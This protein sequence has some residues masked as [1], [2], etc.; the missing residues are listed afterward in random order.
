[1]CSSGEVRS[2]PFVMGSAQSLYAC[3]RRDEAK[4]L[5]A[6]WTAIMTSCSLV[7]PQF[8]LQFPLKAFFSLLSGLFLCIGGYRVVAGKGRLREVL[9][10]ISRMSMVFCFPLTAVVLISIIF[11]AS[12]AIVVF[13]TA[14]VYL[15]TTVMALLGFFCP[16]V[17]PVRKLA[18]FGVDEGHSGFRTGPMAEFSGFLKRSLRR[19]VNPLLEIF[20]FSNPFRMF[21]FPAEV[22]SPELI[23]G[24]SDSLVENRGISG[25]RVFIDLP[26]G[27]RMRLCCHKKEDCKGP[28]ILVFGGNFITIPMM[29]LLFEQEFS[30]LKGKG[31]IIITVN[32]R[33]FGDSTGYNTAFTMDQDTQSIGE[34][35]KQEYPDSPIIVYGWS[36]GGAFAASFAQT[37]PECTSALI[38]D[39]SFISLQEVVQK[40]IVP[41][42]VPSWIVSAI[43]YFSGLRI[44]SKEK[45]Q[46]FQ[47]AGKPILTIHA[48]N[49]RVI[50][51][52]ACLQGYLSTY[53][54]ARGHDRSLWVACS[55]LLCGIDYPSKD[56]CWEV[57]SEFRNPRQEHPGV[58]E[59]LRA[60]SSSHSQ[61]MLDLGGAL[62]AYMERDNETSKHLMQRFFGEARETHSILPLIW[63]LN[64][65][66]ETDISCIPPLSLES[67]DLLE[68]GL[69][70]SPEGHK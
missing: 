14:A 41:R 57:K 17:H 25:E 2:V 51:T 54:H 48:L 39:Q 68:Q 45:V 33:G 18:G 50:P 9:V 37:H 46:C 43:L 40:G 60:T 65:P 24:L 27:G 3:Y 15:T 53:E 28:V 29:E 34:Y 62:A 47:R 36:V 31:Y 20:L 32:P 13:P 66:V 19:V 59:L 5:C 30:F 56:G 67:F 44:N 4:Y 26:G 6:I 38:I 12:P 22:V 8:H 16:K 7:V 35:I 11:G 52:G 55:W 49:D 42:W 61:G 23:S 21:A 63:S 58:E 1:M 70:C 64:T 69:S 10:V